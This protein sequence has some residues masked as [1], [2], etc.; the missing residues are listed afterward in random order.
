MPWGACQRGVGLVG[1]SPTFTR[2]S[3]YA[4]LGS[5]VDGVGSAED[6]VHPHIMHTSVYDDNIFYL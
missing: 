1:R 4:Q 3:G 5:A 2:R 6:G